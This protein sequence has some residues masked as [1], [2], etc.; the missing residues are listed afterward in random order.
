MQEKIR[1]LLNEWIPAVDEEEEIDQIV[2]VVVGKDSKRMLINSANVSE[3]GQREAM[4]WAMD[5][6][7]KRVE[8]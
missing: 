2:V 8:V 7:D 3:V 4:Q 1:R 5:N 6:W